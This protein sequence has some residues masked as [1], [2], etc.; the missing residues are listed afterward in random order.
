MN[1]TQISEKKETLKGGGFMQ[2]IM[3]IL[4]CSGNN[5]TRQQREHEREDSYYHR[6][7]KSNMRQ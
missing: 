7:D 3:C 1:H 2:Y 4:K 5:Q 6:L